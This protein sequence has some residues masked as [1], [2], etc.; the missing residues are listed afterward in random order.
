VRQFFSGWTAKDYVTAAVALY[1]ALLSTYTAWTRWKESRAQVKVTLSTGIT[2]PDPSPPLIVM[3]IANHGNHSVTFSGGCAALRV[4][5]S[6]SVFLI[7]RPMGQQLPHPLAHSNSM[8]LMALLGAM[9]EA[10]K[11]QYGNVR[12]VKLRAE[13]RDQLSRIHAS[14]WHS[15]DL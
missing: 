8:M 9:K 13:V 2:V 15:F 4:K 7:P 12:R 11:G 6:K 5:R 14:K 3:D 1:G 10:V